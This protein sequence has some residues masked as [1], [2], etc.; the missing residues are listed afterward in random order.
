MISSRLLTVLGLVGIV[1][2]SPQIQVP[3]SDAA[4]CPQSVCV[5]GINTACSKRWGG[6]YDRCKPDM[7]PTMPPCESTLSQEPQSPTTKPP[8][9]PT[10]EPTSSE[11]CSTRSVCRDFIND[12][13]QMYGG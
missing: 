6:C 12:C 5:E 3:P 13:G 10:A 4:Q 1:A 7:R 11:N 8:S 9:P 2:A